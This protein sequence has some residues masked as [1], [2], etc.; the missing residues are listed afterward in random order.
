MKLIILE[1]GDNLGKDSL[2]KSLCQH[3]NYDNVTVRHFGKPRSGL[4]SEEVLD[5]Q[6]KCFK[7]EMKLWREIYLQYIC[8]QYHYY[9][10][11]LIWN[12]SHL[13]EY[14]YSQMFRGG[15]PKVLKKKLRKFEEGFIS[16]EVYL[17]TLTAD[18]EFF[19][20]REKLE[21]DG[22]SL[23]KTLQ[24]KMRELEL[25]KEAH[26]FSIIAN[27]HL[28]KVDKETEI[29]TGTEWKMKGPNLFRPKEDI[30]NEVLNFLNEI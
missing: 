6:F 3:F 4:S 16:H 5:F 9:S 27:K 22:G 8:N 23:S 26:D 19:F 25:F 17:I 30:F 2:V 1:G 13:G 20:E 7:K 12:R 28:L 14:V 29:G 21:C 10:E 18:P 15:D 11:T 24:E